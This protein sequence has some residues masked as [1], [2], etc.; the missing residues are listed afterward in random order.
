MDDQKHSENTEPKAND[1]G[2]RGLFPATGTTNRRD[3]G[4]GPILLLLGMYLIYLG[5]GI[6]KNRLEDNTSM[7]MPVSILAAVL[8]ALAGIAMIVYAIM[9]W[10]RAAAASDAKSEATGA[11]EPDPEAAP[12][13]ASTVQPGDA[14]TAEPADPDVSATDQFL[15]ADDGFVA[16]APDAERGSD[17]R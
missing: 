9:E 5:W 7:S 13:T 16:P 4:K 17:S 3:S 6:L 11:A 12:L 8:M 1:S 2:R 15:M 14:P 10:R